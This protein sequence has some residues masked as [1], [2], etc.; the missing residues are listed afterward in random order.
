MAMSETPSRRLAAILAADIAGYSALVG[1]DEARTVRDLKE[2]QAAVLPM[3]VEHGGRVID[4]AGD[5]FLADFASAVNAI[6]CAVAVQARTTE[7][8][9]AVEVKRRMRFRMGINIGDIICDETRVYGDGINIAARLQSIAEP[10]GIVVSRQAQEQV[11]GRVAIDFRAMGLQM[12]KNIAK[13][14]ETYVIDSSG[15]TKSTG[16]ARPPAEKQQQINYCRTSD[17]VRLAWAK[18]GQGPPLVRTANW[19]THL[20]YDWNYPVRRYVIEQLAR[21]H[22]LIRYDARGSGLSDWDVDEVSLDAWVSDLETVIDA[23]GIERFALLGQS[24][25]CAISI[26]YAVRHPERVTKLVFIGGFSRGGARRSPEERHQRKAMATLMRLGWGANESAFRQLFTSRMMPDASKEEADAFNELQRRTTSAECAA[27]Y[28][29]TVGNFD[30]DDLLGKIR[31]PTL[32]MHARGDLSVPFEEG[33][34]MASAIPGARFVA[35]QSNNHMLLPV[36][37]AVGRFIEET[38]LFLRG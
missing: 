2:L 29:E 28:L 26:A 19:L 7:R 21:N 33:R 24:Q 9:R 27:R 34:R 5:G 1:A 30:V 35:L 14:I 37:P 38:E 25:G 36:E 32:V 16:A 3:V 18:V 11:E 8:N 20:E 17:G 10:G 22:T 4:T 23:A 6:E 15:Y 13:P 12:L 31:V